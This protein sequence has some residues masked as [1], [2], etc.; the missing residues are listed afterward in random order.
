MDAKERISSLFHLCLTTYTDPV[1]VTCGIISFVRI[2]LF[3]VNATIVNDELESIV[4]QTSIAS[5]I[6]GF[7]TVYQLLLR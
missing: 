6:I 2:V 4:H 1:G 5:F 7:I 3:T